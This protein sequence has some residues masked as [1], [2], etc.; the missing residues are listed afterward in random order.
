MTPSAAVA[1]NFAQFDAFESHSRLS[2]KNWSD[3]V[4]ECRKACMFEDVDTYRV[5]VLSTGD[6]ES[7]P[8]CAL[9]DSVSAPNVRD[10]GV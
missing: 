9:I 6:R 2:R 8:H 10:S 3:V 7:G 1:E 5:A 4:P